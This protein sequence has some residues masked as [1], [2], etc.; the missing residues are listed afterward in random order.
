[1]SAQSSAS[2]LLAEA[3]THG[4]KTSVLVRRSSLGHHWTIVPSVF[5]HYGNKNPD[6]NTDT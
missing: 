3:R 4:T 1:M 2:D 6:V 5:L